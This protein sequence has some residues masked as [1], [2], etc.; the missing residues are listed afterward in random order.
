[1]ELQSRIVRWYNSTVQ[2]K[3][4]YKFIGVEAAHGIGDGHLGS[5]HRLYHVSWS[6]NL[7]RNI[8]VCTKT[9]NQYLDQ[10]QIRNGDTRHH[11]TASFTHPPA[12]ANMQ[13]QSLRKYEHPNIGLSVSDVTA[14]TVASV[15]AGGPKL[16]DQRRRPTTRLWRITRL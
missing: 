14:H 5:L 13:V 16:T 4:R 12:I 2:A 10:R 15:V 6:A 9:L 3:C 1:M 7:G 8:F 11:T